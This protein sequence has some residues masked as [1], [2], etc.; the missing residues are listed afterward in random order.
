MFKLWLDLYSLLILVWFSSDAASAL[1]TPKKKMER[2]VKKSPVKTE[3][4]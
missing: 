4:P 3:P 1:L 2:V